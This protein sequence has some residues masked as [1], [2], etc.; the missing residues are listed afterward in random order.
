M[1]RRTHSTFRATAL[2]GDLL[3]AAL[4]LWLAFAVRAHVPLPGTDGLLPAGR[5]RFTPSN[6]ALVAGAQALALSLFGLYGSR[7]RFREPLARL[8]VPALFFQLLALSSVYFLAL[9]QESAFPRSVL[10]LYVTIDA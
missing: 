1:T 4:S 7:E 6:I 5:V 9:S 10:V 3:L 8:L 2:A